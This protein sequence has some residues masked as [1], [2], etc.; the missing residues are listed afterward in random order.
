MKST[1][2]RNNIIEEMNS[3]INDYVLH[4]WLF[5]GGCCYAAY[6][7]AKQLKRLGIKY[8]VVLWQ[9][10]D[11]LDETNFYT[12]INGEGVA[13][14]G[15]K[16][17][18]NHRKIII[19]DCSRIYGYFRMTGEKFRVRKYTDI[20]P[21]DLLKGYRNNEWNCMYDRCYNGPLTKSIKSVADKYVETY[22]SKKH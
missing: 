9:H 17:T 13:H 15:I 12:A 14:V 2:I 4:R 11:I 7:L 19:G 5:A 18:Y 3:K 20:E 21:E 1:D 16:V 10:N 8:E 22:I 6:V